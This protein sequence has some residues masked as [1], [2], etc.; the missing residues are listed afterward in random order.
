MATIKDVARDAGVSVGTVSNVLNGGKV[1][2]ERR[3]QVEASI[4][5]LDYQ[6]NTLAKGMRMQ[7][8]DYVVVILPNLIN[9]YFAILLQHLE[10]ALSREGKQV[11]LCLSGDDEQREEKFIEMAKGN[12]I[13]GII[14]ITYSKIDKYLTSSMPF[15]SIDRRFRS[16]I[17]CVSSDNRMGGWLAAENLYQRGARKLLCFQTVNSRGSEVRKRRK[18][19]EEFC[20][21]HELCYNCLEFSEK[22]VTSLYSSFSSREM[23]RSVLGVYINNA[24][25]YL[26]I[27]G[28][29]AS[30]DH[31][32]VVICE[33]IR[34]M[35]KRVPEDIQVIGFDGLR[36]LNQ[37]EPLVSSIEQP[38]KEIAERSVKC[39]MQLLSCG[40]AEDVT[41]LKVKF[42]EGGTTKHNI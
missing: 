22:Q 2:V 40:R 36:S 28:V 42:V 39:L 26:T 10:D 6:V 17:P 29:F 12:K 37:S 15:V 21:E 14:G 1:S 19:F 9:P 32:A 3:H 4:K 24:G 5:K 35:G 20:I 18:G 13:D 8:T 25:Q 33:E 16:D 27:D 23:V 38:V 34:A 11:I 31:L 41:N 30:S 7:K